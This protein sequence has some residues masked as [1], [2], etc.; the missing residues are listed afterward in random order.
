MNIDFFKN[1]KWSC[2]QFHEDFL[3]KNKFKNPNKISKKIMKQFLKFVKKLDKTW[4]NFWNSWT[5]FFKNL[6]HFSKIMN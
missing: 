5:F 4:T 3:Y 6:E 2:F 1:M